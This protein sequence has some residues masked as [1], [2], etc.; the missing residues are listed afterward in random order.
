MWLMRRKGY[1]TEP[2]RLAVAASGEGTTF[3]YIARAAQEG[4]VPVE[5]VL[6]L[7]SRRDNGAA[8]RARHLGVP[9][10]ELV[11]SE[12][13][14]PATW[15]EAVAD[16]LASHRVE[17]LLLAGFLRKLGARTLRT[18]HGQ[19]L[20]THP[21]LL[22]KYGGKGMYGTA[23]HQAVLDSGDTKSGVTIHLV[24][25]EYDS[26]PIVFQKQTG[27]CSGDTVASLKSRVQDVERQAVVEVL[28]MIASGELRL[29]HG[30][31]S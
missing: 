7:T 26:G 13:E 8:Q 18:L 3:E 21:A 9:T 17:L 24:D 16:A 1:S 27:V 6:L 2:L 29:E 31:S 12:F 11:P 14:S 28:A 5:V 23:V 20:N 10:K 22:P 30:R 19:I 25:E 4:R 15:D